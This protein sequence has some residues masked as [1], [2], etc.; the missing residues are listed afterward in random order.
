M[1]K[2]VIINTSAFNIPWNPS[3]TYRVDIDAGFT[4]EVA[5]N[6][7]LSP[8]SPS[9]QTFNSFIGTPTI[10][11]TSPVNNSTSSRIT[12]LEINFNRGVYANSGT[13]YF[14]LF[15]QVGS[16]GSL[17]LTIPS[18]ATSVNISKI[19]ILNYEI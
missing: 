12:N 2:K 9:I 18:T 4:Q 11:T 17:V 3:K 19:L 6:R 8:A 14:S 7:S 15:E 16:T 10:T 1:T 5:N 13:Q